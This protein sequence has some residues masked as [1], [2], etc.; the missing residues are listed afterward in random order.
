MVE[1]RWQALE[2]G[3]PGVDAALPHIDP[4]WLWEDA[5][6]YR[7]TRPQDV[8]GVHAGWFALN[9]HK[10]FCSKRLPLAEAAGLLA[11]GVAVEWS[12]SVMPGRRVERPSAGV[13]KRARR[14]AP[15][16]EA[17]VIIGV[18]DTG[19]P[20]ASAMLRRG[21]LGTRVLS[22]WDQDERPSFTKVRDAYRPKGYGYG[23]AV[24]RDQLEA[25]MADASVAGRVD[26]SRVYRAA[27]YDVMRQAASHGAAVLSQIFSAPVR[28]SALDDATHGH[29]APPDEADLVFVQ[30]PRDAVQDSTSGALARCLIDGLRWIRAHAGKATE[31][32][33]VNISSGTSRTLHDG[34]SLIERALAAL[35]APVAQGAPAEVRIVVAAGNTNDEQRCACLS[36]P[37]AK[38]EL[39]LPPGS[40]MAQFVTVRW[41]AEASGVRLKLTPPG[42]GEAVVVGA[43]QAMG[44][45]SAADPV[46]GVISPRRAAGQPGRSLLVFAPT[47][48]AAADRRAA[49]SGRWKLELDVDEGAPDLQQPVMFWI[50]RN[51]RNL[52]ALRRSS[53]AA[54]VDRLE[55]YNPRRYLRRLQ[56]DEQPVQNGIVRDGAISGL[57]TAA[58][59]SDAIHAVGAYVLATGVPSRYSAMC[60]PRA[61]LPGGRSLPDLLAP[62]DASPGLP[63]LTV[64]ARRSAEVVRVMGTSFAA[65]LVTRWLSTRQGLGNGPLP[66]WLLQ[67]DAQWG[68]R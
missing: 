65:P 47:V 16:S 4:M 50:S 67:A 9:E 28:G 1:G 52:G 53:Q 46:C 6:G 57:A 20:F 34:S 48:A 35:S 18:I 25:L 8:D 32:I 15:V 55:T 3:T 40:E 21:E 58:L 54:F 2:P 66:P 51:Q 39:F 5:T 62:G 37:G 68:D 12:E 27:D 42:G 49:P 7:L 26:E 31:R 60:G 30:L 10:T 44:W 17:K 56:F 11:K 41:P 13:P 61:A 43:G 59:N 23:C 29:L 63:G 14:G 36:S 64:K 33:V 45:P 24:D 22:L 38:L 19:C